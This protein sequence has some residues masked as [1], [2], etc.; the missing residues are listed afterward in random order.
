MQELEG[1]AREIRID[2][3]PPYGIQ[4]VMFR[5]WQPGCSALFGYFKHE[6][7]YYALKILKTPETRA[8]AKE[9]AIL[10]EPAYV[11]GLRSLPLR[12]STFAPTRDL[13]HRIAHDHEISYEWLRA[14]PME[15][16][17]AA[18]YSANQ[19][20]FDV[21]DAT[22]LATAYGDRR[23]LALAPKISKL[24]DLLLPGRERRR[25][26]ALIQEYIGDH[27]TTPNSYRESLSSGTKT[28]SHSRAQMLVLVALALHLVQAR[29]IGLDPSPRLTLDRH[30]VLRVDNVLVRADQS[31]SYIDFF[32]FF[33][34]RGNLA[35]KIGYHMLYGPAGAVRR[36][37]IWLRRR[38]R[39][40]L[41]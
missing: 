2:L 41:S 36:Y 8:W 4:P 27:L 26:P 37:A 5:A 3:R 12:D 19:G 21:F 31:I 24:T 22:V 28:S 38:L 13:A 7:A 18:L 33:N 34:L 9:A 40:D 10:D 15:R 39:R 32:G 17:A 11:R 29:G 35:E 23:F 16:A 14:V 6:H 25:I 20:R 30:P 1:S